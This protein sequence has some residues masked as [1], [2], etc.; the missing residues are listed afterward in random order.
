MIEE[1][2]VAYLRKLKIEPIINKEK[3]KIKFTRSG[4]NEFSNEI[5]DNVEACVRI[6]KVCDDKNNSQL[7]CVQFTKLRGQQLTFVKQFNEYR[8]D[9]NCLSYTD[10][11]CQNKQ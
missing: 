3:Y 5:E 10:D 6:M 1:S 7:C 8:T 11:Y 9:I 2:L 4:M